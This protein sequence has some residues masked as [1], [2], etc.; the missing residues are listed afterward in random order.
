MY[1][2]NI[3]LSCVIASEISNDLKQ[4]SEIRTTG[5][6]F[7]CT[8]LILSWSCLNFELIGRTYYWKSL[9]PHI[10]IYTGCSTWIDIIA[11]SSEL[12]DNKN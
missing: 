10:R 8:N 7:I 6:Y 3:Y 9:Y 1:T 2:I 5:V 11:I 12:K 4:S